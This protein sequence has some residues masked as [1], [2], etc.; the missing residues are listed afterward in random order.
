MPGPGA[1]HVRAHACPMSHWHVHDHHIPLNQ[2]AL[3]LQ[4][5]APDRYP[6]IKLK[7]A[8]LCPAGFSL[9]KL[10]RILA[11]H[12]YA[13]N[14]DQPRARQE[15]AAAHEASEARGSRGGP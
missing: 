14:A 1:P 5:V 6:T 4:A 10:V 7:F 13:R 8:L 12:A 9:Y 2:G 3:Q 11:P 15:P